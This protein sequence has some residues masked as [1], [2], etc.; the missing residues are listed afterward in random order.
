LPGFHDAGRN[1]KEINPNRKGNS[2]IR[3]LNL[4]LTMLFLTKVCPVIYATMAVI[5]MP[6]QYHK[7]EA[8][9][10]SVYTIE[11]RIEHAYQIKT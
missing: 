6:P 9:S 10:P 2:T 11:N 1:L 8:R 5:A 3:M 4:W 7:E